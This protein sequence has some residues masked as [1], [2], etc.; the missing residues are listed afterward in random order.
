MCGPSGW[1]SSSC[2]PPVAWRA[3]EEAS[4]PA[5]AS[6]PCV[7]A[8]GWSDSCRHHGLCARETPPCLH[9]DT[10]QAGVRVSTTQHDHNRCR[11]LTTQLCES[12]KNTGKVFCGPEVQIPTSLHKTQQISYPNVKSQQQITQ[13]LIKMNGQRKENAEKTLLLKHLIRHC[14]FL[15][16]VVCVF[17]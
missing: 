1:R 2:W 8:Q 17:F 7:A 13:Q 15:F 5:P 12:L 16:V 9:P 3:E 11:G 6:Q 10:V 4:V 14:V